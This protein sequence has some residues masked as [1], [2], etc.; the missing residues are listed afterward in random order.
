MT[1][2]LDNIEHEITEKAKI[3]EHAREIQLLLEM[4]GYQATFV[5]TMAT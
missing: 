3:T 5:Y 2:V 1:K 4:K